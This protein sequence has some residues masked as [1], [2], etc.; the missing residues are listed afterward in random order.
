MLLSFK[1]EVVGKRNFTYYFFFTKNSFI[2][3]TELFTTKNAINV[4]NSIVY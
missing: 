4:N 1:K 3:Y 2:D